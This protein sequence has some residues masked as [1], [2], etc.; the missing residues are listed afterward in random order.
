MTKKDFIRRN[1]MRILTP[2]A[3]IA[4][5]VIGINV[6][7]QMCGHKDP[8]FWILMY[9]ILG[10][11]TVISILRLWAVG[12]PDCRKPI[13]FAFMFSGT[14]GKNESAIRLCPHCGVDLETE[15]K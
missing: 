15:M 2:L 6:C 4:V 11:I 3:P 9:A 14:K 12:C 1:V 10:L 5:V 13:G 7:M 8:F